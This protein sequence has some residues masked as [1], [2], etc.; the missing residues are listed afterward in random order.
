MHEGGEVTGRTHP[1]K[2]DDIVGF[3]AHS[4]FTVGEGAGRGYRA[5]VL[6][7]FFEVLV[8]DAARAFNDL[9]R[10]THKTQQLFF[11][12]SHVA[13]CSNLHYLVHPVFR[14]GETE[15]D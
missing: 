10:K 5:F 6:I 14:A 4:R 11:R 9:A 15:C 13:K 2:L 7:D 12:C 3:P 1:V 8:V